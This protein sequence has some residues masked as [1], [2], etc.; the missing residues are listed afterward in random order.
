[1]FLRILALALLL[2][3]PTPKMTVASEIGDHSSKAICY[4]DAEVEA[5]QAIR[6]HSELMVIGLT[7]QRI[8]Q[9]QNLYQKY[10]VFTK[11]HANLLS[12]YEQDMIGYYQRQG[13]ASPDRKLHTLRTSLANSISEHAVRMNTVSFC[14]NFSQRIDIALGMDEDKFRTWAQKVW[15]EQPPTQPI[16]NAL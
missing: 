11:K 3:I 14:K 9:K 4:S 6:I 5:E 8:S 7:C 1:M 15:P 12:H 2:S 16:C 10:R 13:A